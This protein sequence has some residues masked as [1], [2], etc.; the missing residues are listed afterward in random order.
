MNN[1]R[2]VVRSVDRAVDALEVL[3][4]NE[5]PMTLGQIAEVLHAPKSTTLNI[6]RTLVRRWMLE[7]DPATKTY[8]LGWR[9]AELA[10][11]IGKCLDL[12]SL[13]KPHL[14]Q[15]ALVTQEA[16]FLSVLEGNEITFIEKIDSPQPIRYIAQVG[17]RRPLHCTAA[18]KMHLAMLP[19]EAVEA[20]IAETGLPRY[21]RNTITD[22]AR[23]WAHLVL[24]RKRGYSVSKGEFLPDLIGIAVPVFRGAGGDM[25]AAVLTAGP[26]F[27]MRKQARH[28]IPVLKRTADLIGADIAR[29]AAATVE[30]TRA[31]EAG[32]PI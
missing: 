23:L 14:E 22:P 28:M 12:R 3:A 19:P 16:V 26:A 15:L 9:L 25:I 11:R 31:G 18:G 13:A 32:S 27:R 6:V 10:S 2:S 21:T 20:Y 29:F 30:A 7:V 1:P 5:R 24:I 17:T 4:R 8:R